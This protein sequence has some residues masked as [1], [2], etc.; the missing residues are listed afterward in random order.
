MNKVLLPLLGHRVEGYFLAAS[1][2]HLL[3][4]A[5]V[6]V[7]L[8]MSSRGIRT[9]LRGARWPVWAG[10]ALAALAFV[11]Y[12]ADNLSFLSGL[13]Y[14][15][16]AFFSLGALIFSL[17]YL[18][19]GRTWSWMAGI[20]CATL[21][22]LSHSYGLTTPFVIGGLELFVRRSRL[23]GRGGWNIVW[24]YGLHLVP[25]WC[26]FLLFGSSL[27]STRVSGGRI[28]G[29]L[30]D[31]RILWV[32]LLHFV[33]Y[34]QTILTSMVIKTP[35]VFGA[36][37]VPFPSIDIYW[38]LDR[39]LFGCLLLGITALG[40]RALILRERAGVG[41][42]ALLFLIF[43]SGAT[44]HQT[45]LIGY[46][47][48]QDWRFYH[49]VVGWCLLLGF[50]LAR[51]LAM[52]TRRWRPAPRQVTAVALVLAGAAAVMATPGQALKTLEELSRGQ[53]RLKN[54]YSWAPGASCTTR[55]S[56]A[57][58]EV[59]ELLSTGS[60]LACRD[61]SHM[62]LT[63]IAFGAADLRGA[64]FTGAILRNAGMS[65]AKLRGAGFSFAELERADLARADLR[66]ANFSGAGLKGTDLTGAN[67]KEAVMVGAFRYDI[68]MKGLSREQVQEHIDSSIW[69][70]PRP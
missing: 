34:M 29:H 41:G 45:L 46:D 37:Q 19:S 8:I 64:D 15:L 39:I 25:I 47:E 10:S 59:K 55:E 26:Y 20:I 70:A 4:A 23:V 11:S 31:P 58:W 56:V 50:V 36:W 49:N 16:F 60:S 12:Q 1:L 52:I 2:L 48:Q 40:L 66:G 32:D 51:S 42:A 22:L 53:L 61:F 17:H 6:Y 33:N 54:N 35:G 44:F 14:Q 57:E 28:M 3:T 62:N 43:W 27:V 7:F 68:E 67:L 69:R 65:G 24:R 13:S 63:G 5:Q 18:G 9:T 38:S 30:V 21:G